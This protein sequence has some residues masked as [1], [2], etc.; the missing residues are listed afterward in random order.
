MCSLMVNVMESGVKCA[1]SRHLLNQFFFV[2]W[3]YT[4][5]AASD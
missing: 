4:I 1:E 2:I 3:H 5:K